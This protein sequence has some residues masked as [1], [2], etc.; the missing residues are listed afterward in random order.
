MQGSIELSHEQGISQRL[1]EAHGVSLPPDRLCTMLA[2]AAVLFSMA[3]SPHTDSRASEKTESPHADGVALQRETLENNETPGPAEQG[4]SA[5]STIADKTASKLGSDNMAGSF[6][7]VPSE[8][9]VDLDQ[10]EKFDVLTVQADVSVLKDG[11]YGVYGTL[12]FEEKEI[13]SR[14]S[15]TSA[16]PSY[17]YLPPGTS[18]RRVKLH[19]SGEDI[20]ISKVDGPYT[21]EL[22][23]ITDEGTCADTVSFKTRHYHCREFGEVKR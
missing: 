10:D 2:L 11:D 8:A 23:L 5:D 18:R 7:G 21:V 14:P 1:D 15:A 9:A 3:C 20:R 6:T 22:R 13:T 17:C 12:R 16:A 4:T 19:F